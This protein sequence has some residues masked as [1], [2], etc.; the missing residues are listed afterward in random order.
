MLSYY[1]Y[2]DFIESRRTLELTQ[3]FIEYFEL[4]F[5][6]FNCYN[7]KLISLNLVLDGDYYDIFFINKGIKFA[8]L[9]S[10]IRKNLSKYQQLFLKS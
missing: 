1:T 6:S 2:R 10:K 8:K 5:V 7:T 4:V 3:E 9:I